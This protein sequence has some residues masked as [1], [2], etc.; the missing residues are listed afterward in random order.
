M[1]TVESSVERHWVE[2]ARRRTPEGRVV[3]I[4]SVA[5]GEHVAVT[6]PHASPTEEQ[7]E[8]AVEAVLRTVD[9]SPP[10]TREP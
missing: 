2:V 5:P 1:A 6:V 8:R 9:L 10:P 7:V 3:V 4:V